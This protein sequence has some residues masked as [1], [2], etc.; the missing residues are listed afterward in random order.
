MQHAKLFGYILAVA[1]HRFATD[2]MARLLLFP[3]QPKIA[4]LCNYIGLGAAVISAAP[5]SPN[6]W[7]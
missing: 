4:L 3:E 6:C 7:D 5:T 2:G 1:C